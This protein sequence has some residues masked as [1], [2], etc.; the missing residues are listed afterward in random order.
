MSHDPSRRLPAVA[1]AGVLLLTLTG[2]AEA[3]QPAI[4]LHARIDI[5]HHDADLIEISVELHGLALH[6]ARSW[7][8]M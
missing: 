6:H 7:R 5:A 2:G 1:Y 3:Q 4:M 8:A